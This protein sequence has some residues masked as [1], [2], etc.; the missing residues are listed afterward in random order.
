MFCFGV[1]HA[2]L[3]DK[4]ES[5]GSQINDDLAERLNRLERKLD[6]ALAAND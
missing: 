3:K 6:A 4:R 1:M 5:F 2:F